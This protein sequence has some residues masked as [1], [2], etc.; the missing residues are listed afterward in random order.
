MTTTLAPA[1]E[2]GRGPP[3]EIDVGKINVP[4]TTEGAVTTTIAERRMISEIFS[5]NKEAKQEA[6]RLRREVSQLLEEAVSL[7]LVQREGDGELDK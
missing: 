2:P 1:T 4:T 3:R 7:G 5:R 6:V